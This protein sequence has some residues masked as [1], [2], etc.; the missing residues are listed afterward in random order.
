MPMLEAARAQKSRWSG[1]CSITAGRTV[2]IFSR[3]LS[4]SGLR[5]LPGKRRAFIVNI[6]GRNR[7]LSPVNEISFLAWAAT[8]ELMFPYAYGRDGE[9][10]RQLV[11]AAIA[12]IDAIRE[13]D[14]AAP[15]FCLRNR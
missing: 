6:A 5:G 11:R 3:R 2:W 7:V 14:P 10:K 13:A 1:T 12:A 9:L 15:G 8:R 4:S